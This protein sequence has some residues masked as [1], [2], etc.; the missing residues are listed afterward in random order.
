MPVQT[1]N[2]IIKSIILFF[3]VKTWFQNR[4]MKFKKQL[5]RKD[6]AANANNGTAQ[7]N[8][9]TLQRKFSFINFSFSFSWLET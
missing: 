7:G 8:L 1:V 3:T 2:S 5:R 6:A 4:R 9:I